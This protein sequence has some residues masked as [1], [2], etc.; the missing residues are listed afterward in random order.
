[1]WSNILTKMKF[2]KFRYKKLPK[3][4]YLVCVFVTLLIMYTLFLF[5]HLKISGVYAVAS[6]KEGISTSEGIDFR[7]EFYYKGQNYGGT[8][9]DSKPHNPGERYFVLFLRSCPSRNLLQYDLPVPDCLKDSLDYFWHSY[10]NC[11]VMKHTETQND[12]YLDYIRQIESGYMNIDFQ[13]FRESFIDSPK[14]LIAFRRQNEIDSL[15]NKMFY[16]ASNSN[17]Q[18]T[19]KSA[20]QILEIDYTNMMAHKILGQAYEALGKV[21]DAEVQRTILS[22]LLNSIIK[23]GNGRACETAWP[24][25]QVTE[26]G[27]IMQM[28]GAKI[29]N[30]EVGNKEGKCDKFE[31]EVDKDS[32][33]YY[34]E[35]SNI[36]KGRLK[37]SH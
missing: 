36:L 8:F 29:K 16:Y 18:Q 23:N 27:F 6:I 21:S 10:P 9:T 12:K 26:E 14:F 1:M 19:I 37:I 15:A 30:I 32:S 22:G 4:F 33:M 11:P 13:K 31:A 3:F 24:V 28:L 2:I 25:I 5:F 20:N 7:Y 35:T 17:F 34:F